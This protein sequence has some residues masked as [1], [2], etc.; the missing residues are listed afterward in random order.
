MSLATV[1]RYFKTLN[2]QNVNRLINWLVDTVT[3]SPTAANP[4]SLKWNSTD[5]RFEM[6]DGTTLHRLA[7][8]DDVS[9]IWRGRGAFGSGVADDTLPVPADATVDPGEAF[10]PY[11]TFLINDDISI[12]GIQGDDELTTGDVIVLVDASDPTDPANWVGI[13]RNEPTA[14]VG[15]EIVAGVNLVADTAF[16]VTATTLARIDD[17]SIRDTANGNEE[18]SD[19]L[20]VLYPTNTTVSLQS[21][22]AISGLTVVLEGDMP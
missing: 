13:S 12:A 3:A 17:I 4:L 22:V 19:Q 14:S 6:H 8:L 18:I 1:E 5:G 15:T 16:V 21:S 7:T 11:N 10:A 9:S 20:V 2:G